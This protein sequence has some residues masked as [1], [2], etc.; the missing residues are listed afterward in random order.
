MSAL[1]MFGHEALKDRE[2][3]ARCE[4]RHWA[5]LPLSPVWIGASEIQEALAPWRRDISLSWAVAGRGPRRR[6]AHSELS[7]PRPPGRL[8]SSRGDA[9]SRTELAEEKAAVDRIGVFFHQLFGE[10]QRDLVFPIGFVETTK[11][12]VSDARPTPGIRPASGDTRWNLAARG[13]GSFQITAAC[14]AWARHSF[15]WSFFL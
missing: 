2:G 15:H 5:N 7:P 1:R 9:E 4:S 10:R 12:A 6:Q 8:E 14:A 13:R 3:L 11:K